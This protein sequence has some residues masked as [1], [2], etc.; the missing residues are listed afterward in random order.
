M[1]ALALLLLVG[2]LERAE[3]GGVS[4]LNLPP[5]YQEGPG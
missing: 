4:D 5:E 2:R 1:Q 3:V